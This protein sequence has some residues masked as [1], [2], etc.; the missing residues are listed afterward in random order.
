M[1]ADGRREIRLPWN[2]RRTRYCSERE[3]RRRRSGRGGRATGG[4]DRRRGRVTQ[5]IY[6]ANFTIPDTMVPRRHWPCLTADSPLPVVTSSGY[7]HLHRGHIAL[8]GNSRR[9][10]VLVCR[11]CRAEVINETA[12]I[13]QVFARSARRAYLERYSGD[14]KGCIDRASNHAVDPTARFICLYLYEAILLYL[15]D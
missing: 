10:V 2:F 1:W 4:E 3:R 15:R 11:L 9:C 12:G 5:G 7:L 8:G 6:Q 13:D 14:F